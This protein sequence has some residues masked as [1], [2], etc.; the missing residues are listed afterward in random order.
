MSFSTAL[1]ALALAATALASDEPDELVSGKLLVIT[2]E[3]LKF[4]GKPPVRGESLDLPNPTNDPRLEG[5]TLLVTDTGGGAGSEAFDLPAGSQWQRIP[6]NEAKPLK[7]YR[8]RGTATAADPCRL[9][10][11][12]RRA[13]KALCSGPGVTFTPPVTGNVEVVLTVGTDSKRYCAE[14]GG[15]SVRTRAAV[16]KRRN[17]RAPAACPASAAC[18]CGASTPTRVLF[19]NGVGSSSCGSITGGAG[20][21]IACGGLYFGGGLDAVPLPVIVPDFVQPTRF[22]VDACAGT[23]LTVAGTTQAETGSGG[24][25]RHPAVVQSRLLPV[26]ACVVPAT[27]RLVPAHASTRNRVGWTKSGTMTGSGTAS[28]PPPK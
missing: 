3:T 15:R 23:S 11:V 13:V 20:G 21:D 10:L 28:R 2:A 7:G 24:P 5:G 18:D 25:K 22:R 17:A 1:L 26:S 6:P 4:T 19:T 9:V 14:F 12:K 16:A 8:Y 27:V